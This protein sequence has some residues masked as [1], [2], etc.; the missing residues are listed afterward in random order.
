MFVY[1]FKSNSKHSD[2]LINLNN[3]NDNN[4]DTIDDDGDN[5]MINN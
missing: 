1:F 2:D 5:I 3:K 4:D